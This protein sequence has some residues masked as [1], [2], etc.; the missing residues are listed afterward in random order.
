MSTAAHGW[1]R[2]S[3]VCA[4]VLGGGALI[5]ALASTGASGADQNHSP[6]VSQSL[7]EQVTRLAYAQKI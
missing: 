1:T 6:G 3:Q 4:T 5:W 2:F 7:R